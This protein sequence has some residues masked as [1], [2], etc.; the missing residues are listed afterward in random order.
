MTAA[1]IDGS[2]V[3]SVGTDAYTNLRT[4]QRA[5]LRPVLVLVAALIGACQ[6]PPVKPVGVDHRTAELKALG[7]VSSDDGWLLSL[8]EPISFELDKDT[9]KPSMEQSIAST[10]AGLLKAHVR[11]LRIEG[12]TDNSGPRDYNVALSQR[13]AETVAQ[14]FIS[15]GFSRTDVVEVGLGPDHPLQP[16]DTREHRAANRCVVIIVPAEALAP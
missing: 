16:N 7:F 10:A 15:H 1:A 14:E 8:P 3:W 9:L 13:R 6:T 2:R 4:S 12:H 5:V 11:K